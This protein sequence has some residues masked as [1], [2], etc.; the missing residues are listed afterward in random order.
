M[1]NDQDQPPVPEDEF[2]PDTKQTV[3]PEATPERAPELEVDTD[4][5]TEPTVEPV[6]VPAPTPI[7]TVPPVPTAEPAVSTEAA[8][9]KP[10]ENTPGVII[11]QWLSYAFWG[12]LILAIIWLLSIV[13]I[14]ALLDDPVS[15][16]IPYAIAAGVVLLPIAFLTDLFYR[17]HEPIKKTGVAMVIM[18]IH[19]VLFALLAISALI[20]AAFNG[21]NL[22]I[23]TTTGVT[24]MTVLLLVAAGST[25]LY[26]ATFLRVLDPFK[27]KRP[28]FIYSI[29][30]VAVTVLLIVLAIA[31]PFAK[32]FATVNDRR[33]EQSLPSVSQSIN[34][35]IETNEKLP[36]NLGEVT[37]DDDDAKAL[38]E[39]DLVT[40]KAEKGVANA[41]LPSRIE[42]RYQLCATFKEKDDSSYSARYADNDYSSY[43]S[44]S[45][46]AKGE[47]CYKLSETITQTD[48]TKLNATVLNLN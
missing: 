6:I 18:V 36:T 16:A 43:L 22:L 2:S 34:Q 10:A 12:W 13:L 20:V 41:F 30:M 35:Y 17:K 42:Y 29:A 33:L 39:D 1:N 25:L 23:V 32:A 40:Y 24:G 9:V 31:G 27:T 4:I 26:A 11:L 37:F 15:G 19:A 38:V 21:L 48:A 47:V 14:N 8:V 28:V 5:G 44:V 46:H 45:G 7:E 3:Q